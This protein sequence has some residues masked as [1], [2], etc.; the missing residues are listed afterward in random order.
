MTQLDDLQTYVNFELPRRGVV[1]NPTTAAYDGDPNDGGAPAVLQNC[2]AGT[3]YLQGIPPQLWDKVT[4]G[5]DTWVRRTD[6]I[7]VT[8][9]ALN[10]PIDYNDPT[11]VDPDPGVILYSQAFVTA[12]LSAAGASSFKHIMAVHDALPTDIKHAVTFTLAAGVHRPRSGE[13]SGHAWYLAGKRYSE[14]GALIITGSTTYET[15]S[16]LTGLTVQSYA[17]AGNPK[18]VFSGTPFA[19]LSLKGYHA[20][21]SS[22]QVL[23]VHDN[24]DSELY[25]CD[26]WSPTPVAGVDTI[27]VGMPGTVL[28]N[29]LTDLAGSGMYDFVFRAE[30]NI[31]MTDI[32]LDPWD[33]ASSHPFTLR[34]GAPQGGYSYIYRLMIDLFEHYDVLG[35]SAKPQSCIFLDE[36]SAWCETW[37]MRVPP[38]TGSG[39]SSSH[40]IFEGHDGVVV[41]VGAY[42]AGSDNG[43]WLGNVGQLSNA[44]RLSSCGLVLDGLG[45]DVDGSSGNHP[46]IIQVYTGS[47]LKME[48]YGGGNPGKINEIRNIYARA[49]V[50]ESFSVIGLPEPLSACGDQYSRIIFKNCG[51]NG[52]HVGEGARLSQGL[53]EDGGSNIGWGVYVEGPQAIVDLNDASDLAGDQGEVRLPNGA[54]VTYA[55]ITANGPVTDLSSYIE[56][57]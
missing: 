48:Y 34:Y 35:A 13:T 27:Q 49:V 29:S 23:A 41:F 22:G 11:A 2:P 54:T 24:T 38:K 51:I 6:D 25:V 33:Y 19:G 57:S 37:V 43:L 12:Y 52:I 16:G 5:S 44:F 30:C 18:L 55:W 21:S 42:L 47:D 28:R 17:S 46:G 32:R 20:V 40:Y 36:C 10:I 53:Y 8:Q 50:P 31:T 4:S 45:D 9:S 15:Y 1:Y 14:D 3:S 26:A 7:D 39:D 56:A